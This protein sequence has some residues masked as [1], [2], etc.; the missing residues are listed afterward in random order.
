MLLSLQLPF[1]QWPLYTLLPSVSRS[2]KRDHRIHCEPL[3]CLDS[4]MNGGQSSSLGRGLRSTRSSLYDV[5]FAKLHREI[6]K[7]RNERRFWSYERKY[8]VI[9]AAVSCGSAHCLL[10]S[11]RSLLIKEEDTYIANL[12]CIVQSC[13]CEPL[14]SCWLCHLI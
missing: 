1:H 9:S 10:F 11:W 2:P 8:C 4:G 14:E 6:N 7:I 3:P 12:S 13:G 5:P